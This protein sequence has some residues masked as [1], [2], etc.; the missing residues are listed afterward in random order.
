M[1]NQEAVLAS[2]FLGETPSFV[3]FLYYLDGHTDG[4]SIFNWS[5][6]NSVSGPS[7]ISFNK[8]RNKKQ[9]NISYLEA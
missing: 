3:V 7:R 1:T 9:E 6:S 8:R 4:C 2:V 5:R